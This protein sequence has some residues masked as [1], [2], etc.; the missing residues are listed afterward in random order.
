MKCEDQPSYPL[1]FGC[2]RK[3]NEQTKASPIQRWIASL[4]KKLMAFVILEVLRAKLSAH[5]LSLFVR[6][7]GLH[8]VLALDS[9]EVLC[10]P[11]I[12]SLCND[13]YERMGN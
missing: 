12:L 8:E 2:W 10:I 11:V 1:L 6:F 13:I 3:T 4:G 7:K 9:F 5:Y